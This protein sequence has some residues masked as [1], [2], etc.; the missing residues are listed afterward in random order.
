MSPGLC[1][2]CSVVAMT[3]IMCTASWR[4]SD[5]VACRGIGA[6]HSLAAAWLQQRTCCG[7]AC[8][9]QPPQNAMIRHAA[10]AGGVSGCMAQSLS[11][12]A[13]NCCVCSVAACSCLVRG[14]NTTALTARSHIAL[15]VSSDQQRLRTRNY[16]QHAP[17]LLSSYPA[18]I[19]T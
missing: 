2:D 4:S 9:W 8:L 11:W 7:R 19:G 15:N 5:C 10:Y 14:S 1:K 13:G 18:L 17:A 12:L 3:K 16:V 6:L